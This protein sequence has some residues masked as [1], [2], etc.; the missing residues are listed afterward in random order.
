[1]SKPAYPPLT[2]DT[3][4]GAIADLIRAAAVWGAES[5]QQEPDERTYTMVT[6]YATQLFALVK[7]ADPTDGEMLAIFQQLG[8]PPPG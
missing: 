5:T 4:A 1:M 6:Q 7:R 8:A 3:L 2:A